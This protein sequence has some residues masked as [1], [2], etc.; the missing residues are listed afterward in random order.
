M[1]IKPKFS[2]FGLNTVTKV[3]EKSEIFIETS[4]SK[5]AQKID[6]IDKIQSDLKT[7][8]PDNESR[9]LKCFF[10]FLVDEI[11]SGKEI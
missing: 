2:A 1:L 9:A 4:F 6:A 5:N 10:S 7:K 11:N 3:I 8:L